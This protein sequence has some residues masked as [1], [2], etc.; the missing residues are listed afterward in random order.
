MVIDKSNLSKDGYYLVYFYP[1]KKIN[2][3]RLTKLKI[4]I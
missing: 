4:G 1:Y 2:Q 3:K